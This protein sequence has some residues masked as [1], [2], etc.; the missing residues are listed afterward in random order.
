M[1][2][3]L[4]TLVLSSCGT[5]YDPLLKDLPLANWPTVDSEF[6]PYVNSFERFD[7][8]IITRLRM[9]FTTEDTMDSEQIGVCYRTEPVKT[10][11][12]KRVWWNSAPTTARE[13]AVWHELGHCILGREHWNDLDAT[14]NKKSIMNSSILM[15]EGVYQSMRTYYI[16]ELFGR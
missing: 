5:D 1:K 7:G 12:I 11:Y 2:W 14:G 10:I 3:A 6:N 8:H 15:D 16:K 4:L 9:Q 13:R